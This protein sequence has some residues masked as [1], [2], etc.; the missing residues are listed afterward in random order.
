MAAKQR[1]ISVSEFFAKNRH[2]L[3][4]DNPRKALL[5]AVKEAVDN[6][7]DACEEAGILPEI[8]VILEEKAEDRFRMIVQDN[9]PGIVKQQIP[10]VFGKLLYGSK[11]HTLKMSRGQQG[12]GISA[13]GM[14]GQITTGKPIVITSRTGPHKQAHYAE[15]HLD[16]ARNQ[17][18]ILKEADIDW[19]HP[20]GTRVEIEMTGR[21]LRGRA[22]VDEYVYQTA[23][24]NPH[25]T[26][27]Y[28][29][30][31]QSRVDYERATDRLP[32]E[33]KVIK[34]HPYGVEL[35]LLIKMLDATTSRN[36]RGMMTSEFCR[37]SSRAADEICAAAQLKGENRPHG[38]DRV[39]AERLH[40][41]MQAAK[42]MAPPT[43][44]ISPI[45]EDLI[46]AG[47][48]KVIKADFYCAVSRSPVVYRGNPFLVE[49]GIAYGGEMPQDELVRVLRYA[50]RVPLL[51]QQSACATTEG[52]LSIDWKSYGLAQSRGA[53]PAGPAV[54]LVHMASVWVPFTSESKEAV[55]D[56]PEIEKEIKLALQECGRKLASHIRK[57]Q[58]LA[59]EIKRRSI[60]LAYAG[61]LAESLEGLCG[62]KK[63][64]IEADLDRVSKK[65][66]PDLAEPPR[67]AEE[68][69]DAAPPPAGDPASAAAAPPPDANGGEK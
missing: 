33:P 11:F 8:T 31:D 5:T 9:G 46:E 63:A 60:F 59:Y 48:R 67:A 25:V 6:S 29:M 38:V 21:Y 12:I 18:E 56:Y 41:A 44:C 65:A 16:T 4:F 17:P 27:H 57:K 68:E 39:A 20:H 37:V 2:L 55:A 64:R 51:Y 15:I 49:A 58:H 23:I 30:P 36:L 47:L 54:L 61:V 22:S 66:M 1:D 40:K 13:A 53:L 14:Y 24:A 69:A 34:P 28:V 35:G 43:D 19:T 10:K 7:L 52:V 62:V 3:G 50:N 45:G 42:L 32:R 26:F